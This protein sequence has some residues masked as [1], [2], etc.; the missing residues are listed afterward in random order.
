MSQQCFTASKGRG[1]YLNGGR[2][3][4]SEVTCLA[5]ALVAVSFGTKADRNSPEVAR[6][7]EVLPA[8]QAI[9]R[10]GSAALNL[11]MLAA[12]RIDAYWAT[13]TRVWD[14]AA[15]LLLVQEAG[16]VITGVDGGPI[17]LADSRFAAAATEP[18][19]AELLQR[20]ARA[21]ERQPGNRYH[22]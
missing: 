1:A 15:G 16:G 21:V 18:L 12:G 4:T 20:L 6:F 17:D 7:V 3:R 10:F 8:C 14:I 9:R 11:S 19:H 22:R 13:T 2:I 5:E